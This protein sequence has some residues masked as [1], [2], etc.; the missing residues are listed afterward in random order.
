MKKSLRSVFV[1]GI[2]LALASGARAQTPANLASLADGGG[3]PIAPTAGP[4]DQSQL[5]TPTG[6]QTPPGLNYYINNNPPPGQTF[7]TGS[8]PGGYILNSLSIYE[9]GN[10]GGLPGNGQAY[11]LSIYTVSGSSAALYASYISPNNVM[12]EDTYWYQ[13]TNL[14]N[15]PLL[16]NTQYAY[17]FVEAPGDSG[18][19]NLGNVSGD[20]YSG[21]QAAEIPA[22]GGAMTFS[23]TAGYDASFDVGLTATTTLPV[24][25]ASLAFSPG[26]NV[27]S[28]TPVTVSAPVL[29]GGNLYYQWLTDGGSGGA[30]TNIPGATGTN[31]SLNTTGMALGAYNYGLIVS[32]SVSAATNSAYLGITLPLSTATLTDVG[33][34]I[35]PAAGDISQLIG[36]DGSDGLNYYD[37]NGT[38]PGQT[39]TTGAN[40]QGYL[41]N[42][43]TVGTGNQSGGTS[44][45]TG[46]LKPYTLQ[47]YQVVGGNNAVLIA[48][49]TNSSFSFNFG[50]WLTW[51]GFSPLLLQPN[52][53]YAYSFLLWPTAEGGWAAMSVSDSD[54]YAGGQIGLIPAGGGPIAF[55]GSGSADAA[56]DLGLTLPGYP[57]VTLPVFSPASQVYAGTPVTVSASATGSGPFTYQWQTDGGS[58]TLTNIPGATSPALAVDTTALGGLTVGYDL[59]VGNGSD[60]T[61]SEVSELTVLAAQAPTAA[62]D[63]TNSLDQV[64]SQVTTFV[65]GAVSFSDTN[66]QGTLPIAYQWQADGGTGT[67]TNLPGATNDILTFSNLAVSA[68]GNYRLTATNSLGSAQTTA[69]NLTVLPQPANT[70]I[71]NFQYQTMVNA[72]VGNYAGL[73]VIGTGT[74]WNQMID[75][76]TGYYN[77]GSYYTTSGALSD[78]GTTNIGIS[79]TIICNNS[80]GWT[81]TP[82]IALLDSAANSYSPASFLFTLPDGLYNLVLFSCNGTEAGN[83]MGG[84]VFTVNGVSQSTLPTTDTSFILNDN[85]VVFTN[86]VVTGD[87]LAGAWYGPKNYGSLNGAQ[88]QY[89]GAYVP[90]SVQN[91]GLSHNSW[92]ILT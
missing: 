6:A 33:A 48:S 59:V 60:A 3:N 67:F 25:V 10:S 11:L 62:A 30:L 56:F 1:A 31:L 87:T 58:G 21:G 39:F 4:D 63:I 91:T 51:S 23:S 22:D 41:L 53:M 13:W 17:S 72:D 92:V 34:T 75:P 70:F 27:A 29:G 15:L 74:Y 78:D 80:W 73:G 36:G 61:T 54:P 20:L 52:T 71:V 44:G 55:G 12:L 90:L 89:L 81:T 69:G 32:N 47:V 84:S 77:P 16:P 83:G 85:Y 9:A 19:A 2:L 26:A 66:F 42:S 45:H 50:D 82:T 46:S 24:G 88:I 65:G 40:S 49:Y 37:N 14:N 28:G 7:T 8:N 64:T 35:V 5:S 43:V 68:S 18:W 38:P 86:L 57:V 79:W 76:H